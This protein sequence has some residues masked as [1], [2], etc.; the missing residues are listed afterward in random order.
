M[1]VSTFFNLYLPW[2][3][4]KC[5]DVPHPLTPTPPPSPLSNEFWLSSYL[6]ASPRQTR[7]HPW[8]KER[9]SSLGKPSHHKNRPLPSPP[10]PSPPLPSHHHHPTP[11]STSYN[12][13]WISDFRFQV[14][15]FWFLISGFWFLIS[16]F[17]FPISDFGFLISDFG[18]LI[19]D[20]W[21]R[22]SD[23]WFLISD[24]GFLI[25][26]FWFLISDFWF[27]I[28]DFWFPIS[29][30]W[31]RI[32]DF[33]FRVSDFWWQKYPFSD[34]SKLITGIYCELFLIS[35]FSK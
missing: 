20:F 34:F 7:P 11:L 33:W 22:V 4:G 21:F 2:Q 32:P 13:F 5:T 27:L 12:G 31:F 30:F 17:W 6:L 23:F 35:D 8:P 10:L 28:S 16:D 18:F 29:D 15:D 3:L 25:S 1:V 9:S 19:S 24:F 14:S 26:D